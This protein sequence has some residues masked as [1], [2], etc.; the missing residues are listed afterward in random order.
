VAAIIMIFR[1]DALFRFVVLYSALFGAFGF[2][3]P[4][5]PAFLASRGL[6][7]DELGLVLGTATAVRL[8]SGTLAGRLADRLQ[9]FRAELMICAVLA[10]VATLAYLPAYGFWTVAA[11]T[12]VHAAALA[13]LVPLADALSLA[14]AAAARDANGKGFE[15]GW[16]RGAGSAAFIAGAIVA[17]QAASR[18][19][20]SAIIWL[21]AMGLLAA[22]IC[23]LIVP[24]FPRHPAIAAGTKRGPDRAWRLLLHQ[25]AFVYVTIVAALVLGSHAMHDSFA[26]IRWT[27]AGISPATTGLLWSGSVAA[28]VV[29]FFLIGPRLLRALG[30]TVALAIAA[31]S[32]VLRWVVMAQTV[33]VAMLAMI[34][35]LHGFT[36]ALL[37]L[38]CMQII[39]ATVPPTLAGTAQAAYGLIGVGG[40][41]ALLTIFSGWL[42][43]RLGPAGFW[44]MALLC[45][46]AFPVIRMLQNA[47]AV[48]AAVTQHSQPTL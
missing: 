45:G 33:D 41:T 30:P 19:Q 36:F 26:V 14:N 23:A 44:V 43:G 2:A 17:G 11:L 27:E 22:A 29:V 28:E 25:R 8:I 13:P 37:H 10:S 5:L 18:Y 15:Y 42:Y 34:Q 16:V 7:P 39:T 6:A 47:L 46:L 20:L 31:A 21:S 48:P 40:A 4:F 1:H 32:G 35:P 9:A 3:S 24:A 38:A 12:L